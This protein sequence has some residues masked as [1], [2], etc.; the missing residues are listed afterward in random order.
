MSSLKRASLNNWVLRKANIKLLLA[1]VAAFYSE[2]L[3]IACDTAHINIGTSRPPPHNS[4][5]LLEMHSGRSYQHD[6]DLAVAELLVKNEDSAEMINLIEL[7]LGA[8]IECENKKEYIQNIMLLDETSQRILMLFIERVLQ[9][10]S[11]THLAFLIF[12][13]PS[14]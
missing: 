7:I 2:E 4:H 8:A 5:L 3:N 14:C 1:N 9:P 13:L 6:N 10:S 12:L 11:C